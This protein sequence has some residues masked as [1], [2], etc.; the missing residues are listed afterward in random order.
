MK[1]CH[2]SAQ[3]QDLDLNFCSNQTSYGLSKLQAMYFKLKTQNSTWDKLGPFGA[4]VS[5]DSDDNWSK[6]K[7]HED[8]GPYAESIGSLKVRI[9]SC[10]RHDTYYL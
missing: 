5:C 7:R 3:N 1:F 4:R 6:S 9:L 2:Q 8:N 10:S